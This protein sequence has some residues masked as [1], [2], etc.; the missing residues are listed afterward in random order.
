MNV[1]TSL[2]VKVR[3]A[4]KFLRDINFVNFTQTSAGLQNKNTVV[5]TVRLSFVT[6]LSLCE[7]VPYLQ[8]P[9]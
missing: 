6:V 8:L 7:G 3:Y 1:H 9:V 5:A 4:N 2:H